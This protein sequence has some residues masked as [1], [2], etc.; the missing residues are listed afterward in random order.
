MTG[1]RS[2][3]GAIRGRQNQR[4][5]RGGSRQIVRGAAPQSPSCRHCGCRRSGSCPCCGSC[6]CART[7]RHGDHRWP[8]PRRCR[9]CLGAGPCG[10]RRAGRGTLCR[11]RRESRYP[12][13]SKT[14][15]KW[16]S[17]TAQGVHLQQVLR[18]GQRRRSLACCPAGSLGTAI[19]TST[20]LSSSTWSWPTISSG[21]SLFEKITKPKPRGFSV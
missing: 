19:F 14:R 17:G 4:M 12:A 10:C 21:A 18:Q 8:Q 20:R 7:G 1:V 11:R 3:H 15:W 5:G 6:P 13:S 2:F 16:R 9:C